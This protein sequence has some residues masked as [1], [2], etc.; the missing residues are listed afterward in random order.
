M[1]Q[2]EKQLLLK[3]LCARLPYGV[4]VNYKENEHDFYR[5]KISTL[6]APVYSKSGSLIDT[7]HDGWISYTYYEGAGM[8]SGSRPLRLEKMLPYLRPMSSMT[9]KEF[10]EY[11]R[12]IK[13]SWEGIDKEEDDYYVKVK[14]RDVYTDWLLAR[15]F[16]YRGLIPMGLAL[17]AKEGMYKTE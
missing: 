5:W 16:D 2:E 10:N 8:S 13:H 6:H 1:T 9:K 15:H 7:D 11:M 3:D 4:I 17:K 14:D 12:F